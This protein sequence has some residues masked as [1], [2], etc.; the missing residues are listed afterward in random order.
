[1]AVVDDVHV[2]LGAESA[3]HG[4]KMGP[5]AELLRHAMSHKSLCK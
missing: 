3:S 2:T 4:G 1:V 5:V